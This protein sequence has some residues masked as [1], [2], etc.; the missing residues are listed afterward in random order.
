M[1]QKEKLELITQNTEEIITEESLKNLISKKKSPIVY[2]GYE[3]SGPVHLGHLV[4]L[5]KLSDLQKAG[6]KI[7]ILLADIHTKLNKKTPEIDAWTKSI[8]AIGIKAEITLG[9]EFQLSKEYQFDI[10]NLAQKVTINR[11]LR[12]M[13]EVARE[14]KNATIS[15]IIYPLM[16][17]IDVKYL[18]ADVTLGGTD[19]RKIYM[20][21]REE[22]KLTQHQYISINTPLIT[23][24]KGSG[25]KMSSSIPGSNISVTATKKEIEKTISKAYCPEKETTNNPLMQITKLIILPLSGKLEISRQEKFGG[26]TTYISYEDLEKDYASGKLHPADLKSSVSTHLEKIIAPIRKNFK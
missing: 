25:V 14:I 19:Q 26:D 10:L 7:K 5:T 6:F 20:L 1:D 11:G 21:G 15:Q 9:S 17:I 24:L 23:S 4:T 2:C 18:K 22:S 3:I 13:Q 12:S 16:Q 8:K